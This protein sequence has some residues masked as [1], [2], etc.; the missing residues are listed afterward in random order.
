MKKTVTALAIAAAMGAT[1]AHAADFKVNDATTFSV[2]GNLQ[3]IYIDQNNA[4]GD[5]ESELTDNGST[6]GVEG[7][8][9]WDNGL[10]G[11][12]RA[13]W[14][15]RADEKEG[16]GGI[17][18]TDEVFAG[19]KG[20]FG[21]VQIGTWDGIFQDSIS[22]PLNP[23]EATGMTEA[24]GDSE[25]GDQIAYFSPNFGGFT[26]ELQA[27]YEGDAADSGSSPYGD[28][29]LGDGDSTFQA[30][31]KYTTDMFAV[32]LG[33]DDRGYE[34][35]ADGN[36]GLTGVVNLAPVTLAAKLEQVGEDSAGNG[37]AQLYALTGSYDYGVGAVTAAVQEI[38][39]D[40]GDSRTEFL[41]NA[42]YNVASNFYVYVEGGWLDKNEDA[43]DYVSTGAVYS[44]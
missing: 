23:F 27:A 18:D 5:S 22:D 39:P 7:E 26:F 41:I 15:Y 2:Y 34:E 31:A 1:S 43:D 28:D 36:I 44:F 13:E 11:Y 16:D 21:T 12:F 42:N 3:Y 10:T 19:I 8:H 40:E 4:A 37:E 33:Y 29:S 38:D 14:E 32:H 25:V 6:F 9:K 20:N 30:V 17:S 35:D 24:N